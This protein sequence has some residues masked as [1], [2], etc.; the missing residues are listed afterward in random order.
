VTSLMDY[1]TYIVG[2]LILLRDD[3]TDP[4]STPPFQTIDDATDQAT[5]YQPDGSTIS[6]TTVHDGAAGSGV[7]L[8]QF[9]PT[10]TGWHHYVF[11][12]TATAVGAGRWKF[13]V[14]PVP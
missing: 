13:Y 6:P 3:I 10:Q 11:R 12:S 2:Q 8:A 5:V 4:E 1:N 9:A 7:Y 14:S